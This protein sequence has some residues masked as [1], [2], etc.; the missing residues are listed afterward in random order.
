MEYGAFVEI[1]P[2]IEGMVHIS[3]IA[4]SRVDDIKTVLNEGEKVRVKILS[5]A[6]GKKKGKYKI[7]LS[8]KQIDGDPWN[9]ELAVK[10]GDRFKGTVKNA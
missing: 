2:G 6:D 10:V 1:F 3:E 9:Q 7:A 8:I 4:W 5:I